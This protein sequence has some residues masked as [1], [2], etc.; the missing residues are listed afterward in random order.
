MNLILLTRSTLAH[1]VGGVE[2]H[3][4]AVGRAAAELGHAVEVITTAHPR[5]LLREEG[6]GVRT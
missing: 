5:G 1:L 2:T 3:V 4:D 6:A